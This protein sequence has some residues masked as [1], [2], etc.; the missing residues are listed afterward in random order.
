MAHIAQL[1]WPCLT[2]LT[3]RI[4]RL[5]CASMHQLATASWP[6]LEHLDLGRNQLDEAAMTALVQCNWPLLTSL[7][8]SSNP[9][10]SSAALTL[11]PKA[12]DWAFLSRLSLTHMKLD[13]SRTHSIAMLHNR[14]QHLDLAFTGLDAAALSQLTALPW[15]QLQRLTLEGNRLTADTIAS[16]V[17]AEI[18]NLVHINLATNQMHAAA[19]RYLGSSNW[20]KLGSLD[21]ADNHLDDN[22]MAFLA[23]GNWQKLRSLTLR[24][25]DMSVLG[26]ELLMAGQWPQLICLSLDTRLAISATWALLNLSSEA[27]YNVGYGRFTAPRVLRV[28]STI[29]TENVVWPKLKRVSFWA[30][31]SWWHTTL[32]SAQVTKQQ[33]HTSPVSQSTEELCGHTSPCTRSTNRVSDS[34]QG[35]GNKS[36]QVNKCQHEQTLDWVDVMYWCAAVGFTVWAFK[37]ILD[38]S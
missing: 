23:E 36:A 15:P 9:S 18:P 19:A 29:S 12:A 22:A 6:R 11:I 25:N 30:D 7:D 26:L 5:N 20:L 2:S 33:V 14:L 13:S 28:V 17:S 27:D 4:G 37:R 31:S 16:L 8:L 34:D 35:N 24:G 3:L 1:P 10:L 21:L 38:R 32:C